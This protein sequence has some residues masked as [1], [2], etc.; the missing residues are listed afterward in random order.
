MSKYNDFAPITYKEKL[1]YTLEYC[2]FHISSDYFSF[3]LEMETL[4]NFL[5]ENSYPLDFIEKHIGI[6]IRKLY[7]PPNSKTG[8]NFDVPK[9]IGYFTTY[10][11]GNVT[12]VM[13][14]DLKLLV[15][16]FYP[17]L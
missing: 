16:Q 6:V 10:Y 4:K 2:A 11:L 8:L 3:H 14:H 7:K 17:Q 15:R 12:K 1:I 5:R 9:P 13:T